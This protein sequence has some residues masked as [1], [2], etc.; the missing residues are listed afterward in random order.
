MNIRRRA[1]FSR[2]LNARESRLSAG[3]LAS[4]TLGMVSAPRLGR[5]DLSNE[6]LCSGSGME[7]QWL[8]FFFKLDYNDG[9]ITSLVDSLPLLVGIFLVLRC[10]RGCLIPLPRPAYR[11]AMEREKQPGG[12]Y[13]QTSSIV[14]C[15]IL[16]GV[17]CSSGT[18]VAAEQ[19]S[20]LDCSA[21]TSVPELQ[22]T[23]I[24]IEQQT[25]LRSLYI[26]PSRLFFSLHG[27]SVEHGR[28]SGIKQPH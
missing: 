22:P 21:A 6:T 3:T 1:R 12:K 23:P 18:D 5:A 25:M 20:R 27:L 8:A 7:K 9:N 28:G 16:I 26:L 17:G 11:Q 14:C 19:S 15:S 10:Q 4:F 24:R 2:V 13:V